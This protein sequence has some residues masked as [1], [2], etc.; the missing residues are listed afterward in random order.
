L[1]ANADMYYDENEYMIALIKYQQILK[2]IPND[3]E[4]NVKA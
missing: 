1:I 2:N 4:I 3:E